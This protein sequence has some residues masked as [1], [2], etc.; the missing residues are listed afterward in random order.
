MLI[1]EICD[2]AAIQAGDD[3]MDLYEPQKYLEWANEAAMFLVA[4]TRSE[5]WYNLLERSTSLVQTAASEDVTPP[6]D[7]V[8]ILRFTRD[9][10]EGDIWDDPVAFEQQVLTTAAYLKPV[11][12]FPQGCFIDTKFKVRPVGKTGNSAVIIDYIKTIGDDIDADWPLA[13]DLDA[14]AKAYIAGRALSAESDEAA[15][16]AASAK[17]EEVGALLPVI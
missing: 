15:I 3:G 13:P 17:L 9:A 1:K 4:R 14:A 5:F 10:K 12:N 7:M 6:I 11:D 8:R 2:E 16:N